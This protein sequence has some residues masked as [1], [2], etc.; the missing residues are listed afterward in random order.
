[1]GEIKVYWMHDNGR[2]DSFEINLKDKNGTSSPSIFDAEPA[3][4]ATYSGQHILEVIPGQQYSVTMTAL[5]YDVRSNPSDA[6]SIT[7]GKLRENISLVQ[8]FYQPLDLKLKPKQQELDPSA[9]T[10]YSVF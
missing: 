10:G 3:E 5:S 2:F 1:M 7:A 8:I 4:S 6:L 9:L